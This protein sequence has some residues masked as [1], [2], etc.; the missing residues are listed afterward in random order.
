MTDDRHLHEAGEGERSYLREML[1]HQVTFNG[2]LA[3]LAASSL[4][5][6]PYDWGVAA[7]PLLGFASATSL[8][9]LF[10]PGTTWFRRKVDKRRRD[11]RRAATRNHLF[12]ELRAKVGEEHPQWEVYQRMVRRV[13]SLRALAKKR[14]ST[15]FETDIERIDDATVDYLGLWLARL[16][17]EERAAFLARQ[18]LE[19]KVAETRE[20]LSGA[21][22]AE[23]RALEKALADLLRLI[24]SQ[25]RLSSHRT[26]VDAAMLAM[27]DALEE[28]YQGVMANP[29]SNEAAKRLEQAV[30]RMRIEDDLGDAIEDD[31]DGMLRRRGASARAV[32]N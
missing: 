7:L 14:S 4:L 12:E 10:V 8:A 27:S 24:D 23:R 22:A 31:L 29:S 18:D 19:R 11:A 15:F 3:S 17:M 20:R 16:S 1:T 2:L 5:A 26:A 21:A 6:I 28:V 13:V 32:A 9:A 30:D 25:T